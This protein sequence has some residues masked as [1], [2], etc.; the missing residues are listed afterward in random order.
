LKQLKALL[1][2]TEGLTQMTDTISNSDKLNISTDDARQANHSADHPVVNGTDP[3]LARQ[4]VDNHLEPA[5]RQP[6][7]DDL[8]PIH[9]KIKRAMD[10]INHGRGANDRLAVPSLQQLSERANDILRHHAAAGY[11]P[12]RLFVQGRA[13][14]RTSH[15]AVRP[16]EAVNLGV[17]SLPLVTSIRSKSRPPERVYVSAAICGLTKY[18][19]GVQVTRSLSDACTYISCINNAVSGKEYVKQRWSDINCDWHAQGKWESAVVDIWPRHERAMRRHLAKLGTKVFVA[20]I[21]SGNVERFFHSLTGNLTVVF[22]METPADLGYSGALP[23]VPRPVDLDEI[24]HQVHKFTID[25]YNQTIHRAIDQTPEQAWVR[26]TGQ[27]TDR[28]IA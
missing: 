20:P 7:I 26:A 3:D 16:L 19:L 6:W 12:G 8:R 18:A 1:S 17:M 5:V 21:L 28:K 11:L 13:T 24:D 10:D 15:K 14:I 27:K 9:G 23:A 2:V 4:I 25:I 22:G